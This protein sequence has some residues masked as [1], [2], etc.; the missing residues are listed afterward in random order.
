M[1]KIKIH[2]TKIPAF[3]VTFAGIVIAEIINFFNSEISLFIHFLVLIIILTRIV[4]SKKDFFLISLALLSLLRVVNYSMPI[5]FPLTIYRFPLVYSSVFLSV[6]LVIRFL[7]L[8][9]DVIGL[10]LKKWYIYIPAGFFFGILLAIPEYLILQPERL[11]T[12]YSITSVLTLSIIMYIFIGLTEEL[13]FRSAIQSSLEIEFGKPKGLLLATVFFSVMHIAYGVSEF[14][15]IFFAGLLIGYI[16]QKTRS[17]LFVTTIHGTT[18]TVV[19]GF[20]QLLY[21]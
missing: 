7:K 1:N 3:E 4:L 11:I 13:V 14:I 16:F 12:D 10:T 17:L 15:Y 21:G 6:Y 18:N 8:S 5:F 9:P 20:I 19:F 2:K